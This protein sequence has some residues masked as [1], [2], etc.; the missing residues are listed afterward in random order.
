[1]LSGA[2]AVLDV[3]SRYDAG[4]LT[5]DIARRHGV[6]MWVI[7]RCLNEH[8]V[9]MDRRHGS[10]GPSKATIAKYA[11]GKALYDNGLTLEQV[12][13]RLGNITRQAVQQA[14]RRLAKELADA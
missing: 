13:A 4:E 14:F 3:L 7:R 10:K 2:S 5:A 12:G 8:G 1:L 11:H 9:Q 6:S